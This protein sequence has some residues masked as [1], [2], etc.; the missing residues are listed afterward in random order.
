MQ[1][2][3]P[4]R[5]RLRS[6]RP[7]ILLSGLLVL[8][9][10]SLGPPTAVG[11]GGSADDAT[12]E[13][14]ASQ[15]GQDAEELGA[16][17]AYWDAKTLELVIVAQGS[18]PTIPVADFAGRGVSV[19]SETAA[20]SRAD[21]QFAKDAVLGL[22]RDGK[23]LGQSTEVSLDLKSGQIEIA[24][25]AGQVIFADALAKLGSGWVFQSAKGEIKRLNRLDDYPPYWGGGAIRHFNGHDYNYCSSG[26][27]VL[28]SGT[29]Y[30]VTA[31]HCYSVG[32]NIFDGAG[33]AFGTVAFRS[34]SFNGRDIELI[35]GQ[36]YGGYI[37]RGLNTGSFGRVVS[38][39]DPVVGVTDYC[40]SGY[41][42]MEASPCALRATGIH[43]LACDG[44]GFCTDKLAR[45]AGDGHWK[46]G[47]SGGPIFAKTATSDV[48]A[49]AIIL[50]EWNGS[51][52]GQEWSAIA[53]QWALTICTVGD[54]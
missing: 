35:G 4:R 11:N 48:R 34:Y 28:K 23:L 21:L 22:V 47:D 32:W 42:T 12:T 26:F 5:L 25:T 15:I 39:S 18:G 1:G 16:L 24:S 14:I 36:R 30:M 6:M 53:N 2:S 8:G 20:V 27:A 7:S 9:V 10:L 43:I 40:S 29:P 19:R 49:R 41:L 45:F 50:F 33:D 37:W 51:A 46:K 3:V 31:G 13:D 44:T 17:G 52:Y 54:C 38:A